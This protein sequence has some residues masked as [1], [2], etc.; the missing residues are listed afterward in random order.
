M[1]D[2]LPKNI[3]QKFFWILNARFLFFFLFLARRQRAVSPGHSHYVIDISSLDMTP[4]SMELEVV[5]KKNNVRF[6]L[7]LYALAN[8]MARIKFNEL[9]PLKPRYEIPV[10]DVLVKEPKLQR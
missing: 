2:I 5:N 4:S 7:E 6:K 3:K 10:G 9:S 1:L 8:N